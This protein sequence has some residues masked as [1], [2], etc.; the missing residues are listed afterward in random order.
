MK[1]RHK[2]TVEKETV[3]ILD[4]VDR[5]IFPPSCDLY[6]TIK[7]AVSGVRFSFRSSVISG[8][9]EDRVVILIQNDTIGTTRYC[10]VFPNS[11]TFSLP[12]CLIQYKIKPKITLESAVRKN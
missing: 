4:R 8:V 6:K 5:T 9:G 1:W 7:K 12:Y 2:F 10:C 11:I 3:Y